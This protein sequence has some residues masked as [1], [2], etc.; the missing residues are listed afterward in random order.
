VTRARKEEK[1]GGEDKFL[2]EYGKE[3]DDAVSDD[4]GKKKTWR[5]Q[6]EK[7][8]G[9]YDLFPKGKRKSLLTKI[10]QDCQKRETIPFRGA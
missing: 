5:H 6:I 10:C 4:H 3:K 1:G 2:L 9:S 8:E 7:K